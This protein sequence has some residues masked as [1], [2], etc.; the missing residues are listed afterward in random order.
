MPVILRAAIVENSCC[1]F[2]CLFPLVRRRLGAFQLGWKRNALDKPFP[3]E[4]EE[5]VI[6][7]VSVSLPIGRIPLQDPPCPDRQVG[8]G[9]GLP[10]DAPSFLIQNDRTVTQ[11]VPRLHSPKPAVRRRSRR[12]WAGSLA[13]PWGDRLL[14]CKPARMFVSRSAWEATIPLRVGNLI[15]CPI[16]T[17]M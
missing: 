4:P 3:I 1:E 8:E 5:G 15:E 16:S 10:L 2:I 17:H 14:A 13:S 7:R 11:S 6:S 9:I 12:A